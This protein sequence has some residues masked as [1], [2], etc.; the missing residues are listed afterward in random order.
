MLYRLDLAK[1]RQLTLLGRTNENPPWRHDGRRLPYNHLILIVSG[2]CACRIE[3]FLFHAVTGDLI[4]IPAEKFYKLTTNDHCEYC[5]GCFYMDYELA[6]EKSPAIFTRKLPQ[7]DQKFWL[8]DVD[9]KIIC[10]SDHVKLSEADFARILAIFTRCQTLSMSGKYSDRL[11]IDTH[12]DE[13]LLYASKAA[14]D[15]P[16]KH[17]TGLSLDR[18]INYI[19]EHYSDKITPESLSERFGLSKEH[20]CALFKEQF[21]VSVSEYVHSVKLNHATEL[22]S[23]SAMN[24]SQIADYLGYS[25]VYYF[26]KLFKA[27]FGVSPSKYKA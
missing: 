14:C 19:D 17:S 13:L 5:F 2:E 18:M 26:S 27:R 9:E 4:F 20:I 23:N 12:F 22:L 6:D 3:E 7:K 25:S 21:D 1:K 16:A 15:D 11:L 24:I 8:P 10:L